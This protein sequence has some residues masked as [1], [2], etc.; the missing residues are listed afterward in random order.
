MSEWIDVPVKE[1]QIKR[2]LMS[3]ESIMILLDKDDKVYICNA[4]DP[5]EVNYEVDMKYEDLLQL[6]V[7]PVTI[8]VGPKR[9]KPKAL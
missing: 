2:V 5:E 1:N 9:K 6:L 3:V 8:S 4:S 7:Q